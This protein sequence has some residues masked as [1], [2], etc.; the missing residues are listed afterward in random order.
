MP[1]DEHTTVYPHMTDACAMCG[2]FLADLR[3]AQQTLKRHR[4]QAD[5]GSIDRQSAIRETERLI[6]DLQAAVA[7]HNQKASRA[8]KYHRECVG[9][10]A[11]RY[12]ALSTM[13]DEVLRND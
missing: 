10:A 3:Q 12:E 4:Q 9:G 5:Q 2:F 11:Q 7:Q 1:S 8:L 6:Q 13:F